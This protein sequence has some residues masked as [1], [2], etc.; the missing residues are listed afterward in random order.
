MSVLVPQFEN[1][2]RHL[3]EGMGVEV[4]SLDKDGQ[5]NVFQM[6][7]V[8]SLDSLQTV[9]STDLVKE[10][11]VLFTDPHGRDLGIA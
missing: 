11:K 4:S 6:G 9:F 7:K 2:L 1:G 3:L 5:Q 8:L 10:M